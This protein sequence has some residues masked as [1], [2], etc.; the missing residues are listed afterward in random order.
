MIDL[1]KLIV[2]FVV[3]TAM[4]GC[5]TD[6]NPDPDDMGDGDG[7]GSNT[8]TVTCGDNT[9]SATETTAS[10]PADCPVTATCGDG[11]CSGTETTTS[12]SEDCGSPLCTTS[13]DNCTGDN[14][15]I[16]GSCV[17]AFGRVYKLYLYDGTMPAKN[18]SNENWDYDVTSG[19]DELPDPL[20]E[21]FHNGALVGETSIKDDTLS[22]MWNE[23][24]SI[25][26]AAGATIDLKVWNSN[27]GS[28]TLMFGCASVAL[29]SD[30]LR[31]HDVANAAT[32]TSG[33]SKVRYFFVPQ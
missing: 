28:D 29:T 10:C 4:I 18:P 27:V 30:A 20:I 14:V 21:L 22:P 2:S 24:K 31:K 12:C 25:S 6:E 9:C 17:A 33:T 16:S 1:S 7:D 3:A 32:C 15:C 19:P 11:T 13:P 5:A 26:V 23:F 8:N